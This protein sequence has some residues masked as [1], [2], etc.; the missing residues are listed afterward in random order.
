MTVKSALEHLLLSVLAGVALGFLL[1]QLG[2]RPRIWPAD[3]MMMLVVYSD[4]TVKRSF[5]PIDACAAVSELALDGK[6]MTSGP[7][8]A[9]LPY[10]MAM[11][12]AP[13]RLVRTSFGRRHTP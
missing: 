12:C 5:V 9:E 1:N 11:T 10:A 4:G 8:G 3:E 13:E 6:V 7:E 2:Y